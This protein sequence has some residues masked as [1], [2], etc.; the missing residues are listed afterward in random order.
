MVTTTRFPT[1]RV[2]RDGSALLQCFQHLVMFLGCPDR[3]RALL[4]IHLGRVLN[5]VAFLTCWDRPMRLLGALLLVAGFLLCVSIV[6][7]AL[8]FLMMGLGLI[9]LLI[10][11][12]KSKRSKRLL[13]STASDFDTAQPRREPSFSP[14]PELAIVPS[15]MHA[16]QESIAIGLPG[17]NEERWDAPVES[18]SKLSRVADVSTPNVPAAALSEARDLRADRARALQAVSEALSEKPVPVNHVPQIDRHAKETPPPAQSAPK[19]HN[20]RRDNGASAAP[21]VERETR[22]KPAAI[23]PAPL[24]AAR[25]VIVDDAGDLSDLLNQLDL[26]APPKTG[27]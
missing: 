17:G 20:V 8:G 4:E 18:D 6:W 5:A 23:N 26:V 13:Q 25:R 9:C 11:E 10:A 22:E 14:D 7:A 12:R 15:E 24:E 21:E 27:K 19:S 3:V 2:R 1:K 16:D